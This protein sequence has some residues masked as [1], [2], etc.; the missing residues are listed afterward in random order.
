[1]NHHHFEPDDSSLIL[2]DDIKLQEGGSLELPNND[3]V[4]DD[5]NLLNAQ[6]VVKNEKQI[7]DQELSEIISN[8]KPPILGGNILE[9]T[10]GSI[11]RELMGPNG[12]INQSLY[13][14]GSS[15]IG[16]NY[17]FEGQPHNHGRP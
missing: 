5:L 7:S 2:E 8:F 11:S 6:L 17:A 3:S 12:H 9:F 13:S 16:L 10:G 14:G 1:M 15:L 4:A